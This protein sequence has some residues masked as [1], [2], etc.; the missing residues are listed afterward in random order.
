MIYAS[1]LDRTL[2]YS[3]KFVTESIESELICV[4]YYQN[5]VMSYMT[6]RSL[7][8]LREI[9][10]KSIFIPITTRTVEQYL[11]I[12][13]FDDSSLNKYA[14]T[15]NGGNIL[16]H[17]EI[18]LEWQ[19]IVDEKLKNCEEISKVIEVHEKMVESKFILKHRVADD[20]FFYNVVDTDKFDSSSFIEFDEYL[21][22]VG[23]TRYSQGRKI[24]FIPDVLTKRDALVYLME[25]EDIDKSIVSGDSLLDLSML[26]VASQ[27]I[28]P[29]HG[30]LVKLL[31]S[32]IKK[33]MFI[34]KNEGFKATEEFLYK[35]R[36]SF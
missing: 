17:R 9:A 28:I 34:T 7:D 31:S 36:N 10:L 21:K 3:K 24:Y 11:R 19:S 27:G 13:L 30:D 6:Q 16:V 5:D 4:E 29:I 18:D 8:L 23:W 22:K 1:D 14:V 12:H 26:E 32:E 15:T 25:K 33:D 20:K 35:I 2:I